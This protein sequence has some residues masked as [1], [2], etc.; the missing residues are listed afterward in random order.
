MTDSEKMDIAA[1]ALLAPGIA[2]LALAMGI[3]LER[4]VIRSRPGVVTI[5]NATGFAPPHLAVFREDGKWDSVI[6]RI[7]GPGDS[8]ME[9]DGSPA[10]VLACVERWNRANETTEQGD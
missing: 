7:A 10:S 9:V 5:A 6:A 3:D 1:A 2:H 8:V 4:P